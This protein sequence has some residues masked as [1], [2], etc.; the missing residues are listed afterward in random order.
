MARRWHFIPQNIKGHLYSDI[1]MFPT[2]HISR[3][4]TSACPP[5]KCDDGTDLSA[6]PCVRHSCVFRI[7][8]INIRGFVV[9]RRLF[10]FLWYWASHACHHTMWSSSPSVLLFVK[11]VSAWRQH[12]FHWNLFSWT[13]TSQCETVNRVSPYDSHYDN[14]YIV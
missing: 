10:G 14:H 9:Q 1:L 2:D 12:V 13:I 4:D 5:W 7:S 11:I 3:F 6:L 8:S